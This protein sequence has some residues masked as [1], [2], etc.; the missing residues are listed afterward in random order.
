LP[1]P[2]ALGPNIKPEPQ[3]QSHGLPP[4]G[5]S[6]QPFRRGKKRVRLIVQLAGKRDPWY[7]KNFPTEPFELLV[8]N[9]KQASAGIVPLG[10][11]ISQKGNLIID[12]PKHTSRGALTS[13]LDLILDNLNIDQD[14]PVTFV[15]NQSSVCIASVP[16]RLRPDSVVF[17]EAEL[18]Q[19]LLKNPAIAALTITSGPRWLHKPE[20]GIPPRSS[21][22]FRFEDPE[23]TIADSLQ[24]TPIYVFGALVRV[25]PRFNN[26]T[27]TI[28]MRPLPPA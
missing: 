18:A 2:K 7:L 25:K 10:F 16:T 1:Y 4:A 9:L 6:R 11:D 21:V 28:Q 5:T 17:S 12:F 14:I 26:F 27:D 24:R 15:I 8:S 22:V 20:N 3:S 19:S 13:N 23:G